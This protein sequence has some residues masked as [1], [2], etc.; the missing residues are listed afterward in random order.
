MATVGRLKG[1]SGRA[2][3]ST[4][5]R[6][7]GSGPGRVRRPAGSRW[8][9]WPR[10]RGRLPRARSTDGQRA[11]DHRGGGRDA[12]AR[13]RPPLTRGL[14]QLPGLESQRPRSKAPRSLL[15][16]ETLR[17]MLRET[18]GPTAGEDPTESHTTIAGSCWNARSRCLGCWWFLKIHCALSWRCGDTSYI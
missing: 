8:P 10:G 6:P 4:Q 11:E 1:C 9:R 18:P 3:G 7:P 12:P 16:P 13:A 2:G 14:L 17:E 5:V 15:E